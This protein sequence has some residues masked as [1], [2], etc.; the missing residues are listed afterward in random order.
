[1]N[2]S[3]KI[4]SCDGNSNSVKF[5]TPEDN[6]QN[7]LANNR[8]KRRRSTIALIKGSMSGGTRGSVKHGSKSDVG[9]S[10]D[11]EAC[12][13]MVGVVDFLDRPVMGFIRL[14]NTQMIGKI[15]HNSTC[16]VIFL[17]KYFWIMFG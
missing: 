9:M 17:F 8:Y 1:M 6:N 15:R 2:H 3:G 4:S 12:A 10:Q 7:N 14:Q 13:I 16:H 11:A 5:F